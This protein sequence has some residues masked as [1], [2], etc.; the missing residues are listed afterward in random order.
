M[1]LDERSINT[2]MGRVLARYRAELDYSQREMGELLEIGQRTVSEMES[3][4]R[5]IS[6]AEIVLFSVKLEKVL[7]YTRDE[8]QKEFY[9]GRHLGLIVGA[10][11]QPDVDS[12]TADR[13]IPGYRYK[14]A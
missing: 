3:G 11:D 6:A 2:A 4:H 7:P 12:T 8:I 14:A 1:V 9:S 5:G 13:P 10:A